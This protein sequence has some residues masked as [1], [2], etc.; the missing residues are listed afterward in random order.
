MNINVGDLVMIF[1]NDPGTW[2]EA[3][4]EIG[5]VV[6]KAKRLHVPAAK[7]LVLGEVVEFDLDELQR[8]ENVER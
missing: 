4:N 2:V 5:I 8:Q 1:Q 6:D 3:E 7:V